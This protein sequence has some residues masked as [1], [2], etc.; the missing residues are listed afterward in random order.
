MIRV[1]LLGVPRKPV[2]PGSKI[3]LPVPIIVMVLLLLTSLGVCGY[4]HVNINDRI[5]EL[6]AQKNSNK[7]KLAA[8]QKTLGELTNFESAVTQLEEKRKTIE[9]LSKDQS[10]PVR[11]LDE[12]SRLLPENMWLLSMKITNRTLSL[13][14]T[15]YTNDEI[16]AYIVELKNSKLFIKESVELKQSKER[17]VALE[18][19]GDISLY[20]F[21]II[22]EIST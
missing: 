15:A 14:G 19:Q 16:V 9:N 17:S 2:K 5:K 12:V 20:D 22:V 11:V 3:S 1:N 21:D 13:K 18:T 10:L 4:F 7:N 8:L 6:T